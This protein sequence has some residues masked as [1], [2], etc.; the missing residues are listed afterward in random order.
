M[1]AS[2][3]TF[4][5]HNGVVIKKTTGIYFVK[6]G[7]KILPCA[8]STRLRKES[9]ADPI[10]IGDDVRLNP[11]GQ[12]SEILPRRNHLARRSAVPMPTA[13]AHEQIIAANVDQVIPVFAAAILS[14][15][16]YRLASDLST[17]RLR[18][19]TLRSGFQFPPAVAAWS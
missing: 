9:S 14:I 12:I 6:T 16:L 10:A 1:N 15:A 5:P 4:D 8:L 11:N 18:S 2:F 17:C 13:H 3:N 19:S 7:E